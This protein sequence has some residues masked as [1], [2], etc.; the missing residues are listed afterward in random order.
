MPRDHGRPLRGRAERPTGRRQALSE[1]FRRDYPAYQ[2]RYVEFF[3]EHLTDL[4]RTFGGD[5]EQM[6][7]LALLGQI[8]LRARRGAAEAGRDWRSLP[9]CRTGTTASRL[10]DVSG[11]PR[12]TVRRKLRALE[13]KGWVARNEGGLW[14]IASDPD[15]QDS[16]VRRDLADLDERAL[17]R[18]AR[19]VADLDR[20]AEG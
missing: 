13:A 14:S 11:I 9:A 7:V 20:M 1:A 12:E 3:L 5:L 4:S 16:Q 2:Y 19:L 17:Q 18:V 6:M 15:G 8:R 10:A